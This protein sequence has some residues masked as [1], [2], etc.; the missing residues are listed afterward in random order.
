MEFRLLRY[1]VAV[2]EEGHVGRAAARLHMTQPP[3]S[4]AIKQLETDLGVMLLRRTSTGVTP[5]GAGNALYAEATTLLERAEHAR[6]RVTAA[7]ETVTLTVGT[8]ADTAADISDV[9]A[10]TFR[11]EHPEVSIRVREADF[12]D[13]TAGLRNGLVDV[14]LTRCPFDDTGIS[15]H[16]LRRDQV[17][18]VLRADDPLAGRGPLRLSDLDD[19]SWFQLPEGTDPIWSAYWNGATLVGQR[20]AGLV[21]RTANECE[22]AVLWNGMIG[23]APLTH[24][25]RD[26]LA[27]AP[28]TDMPPSPVVVAWVTEDETPLIRSFVSIA[29]DALRAPAV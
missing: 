25:L 10:A 3:L 26:G 16:T 18:V 14:A 5:T 1:F 27:W 24:A 20:R 2:V 9:L 8:L 11:R 7:G 15:V 22:Q 21:V 23:V 29:A 4:R 19:R 6:G 17:G 12:S 13:P 28:L